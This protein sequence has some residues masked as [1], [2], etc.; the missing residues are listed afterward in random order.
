M[1]DFE[2]QKTQTFPKSFQK[3]IKFKRI[4]SNT[5]FRRGV[6]VYFSEGSEETS[7]FANFIKAFSMII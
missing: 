2:S 3:R 1:N 7:C 6:K 4:S 5:F